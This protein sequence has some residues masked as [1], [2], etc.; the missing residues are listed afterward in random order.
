MEEP[1]GQ[2]GSSFL[3]KGGRV[4]EDYTEGLLLEPRLKGRAAF[5]RQE[6][7]VEAPPGGGSSSAWKGSQVC[8]GS[9]KSTSLGNGAGR[10][11]STWGR[12]R[13]GDMLQQSDL[14]GL[15]ALALAALWLFGPQMALQ[16][17]PRSICRAGPGGC[18]LQSVA[19]FPT[20]IFWFELYSPKWHCL[21]HIGN[22]VMTGYDPPPPPYL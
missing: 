12:R 4:R 17:W 8:P 18:L 10:G 15:S 21:A 11:D 3:G 14:Q 2:K 9:H 5:V 6:P 19:C 16:G 13:G 7:P 1:P 22:S 20:V